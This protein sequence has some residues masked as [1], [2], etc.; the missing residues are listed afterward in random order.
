MQKNL[1][2]PLLL[3][4]VIKCTA[5]CFTAGIIDIVAH[6][7]DHGL[8]TVSFGFDA[9]C[10]TLS[11]GLD[12]I[13]PSLWLKESLNDSYAQSQDITNAIG[14]K[15]TPTEVEVGTSYPPAD[16]M[17]I[18]LTFATYL[19]GCSTEK[20]ALGPAPRGFW[21]TVWYYVLNIFFASL[22][23]TVGGGILCCCVCG[24]C[25][26]L[27][28]SGAAT[29][30]SIGGETTLE[31]LSPVLQLFCCVVIEPFRITA[32]KAQ[33]T[34]LVNKATAA[35]VMPMSDT[36]AA[37]HTVDTPPEQDGTCSESAD[38]SISTEE[39]RELSPRCPPLPGVFVAEV[40][41]DVEP[42]PFVIAWE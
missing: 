6:E 41:L 19:G 16:E 7:E 39:S 35:M 10:E 37:S 38:S 9:P 23:I 2:V 25:H 3:V 26:A 13:W 1:L 15:P 40:D 42:N 5:D 28:F 20:Y 22:A 17:Y 24:M 36:I 12:S 11:S 34:R 14:N 31:L 8:R 30:A 21:D 32:L 18:C 4:L 27:C 29:T 33:Q